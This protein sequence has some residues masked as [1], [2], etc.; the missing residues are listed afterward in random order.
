LC[1]GAALVHGCGGVGTGGTGAFASGPITGYG[2]IV[3]DGVFF[4]ES[5]ARIED[6][7]GI[8]R[9]RSELRLGSMVEIDSEEIRN[10]AARASRVRIASAAVGVVDAVAPGA[11]VVNGQSVHLNAGTVID[12][13]FVGGA[14]GIAPGRVVEVHGLVVGGS[15]ELIATR[16]QP[17]DGATVFK[18]RGFV[19]ALDTQ[20]RHFRIGTQ[21]FAY[22]DALG[23]GGALRD[24]AFV[25][26]VFGTVRDAQGRWPV[27]TLGGGAPDPGERAQVRTRGVVTSFTSNADFQVDGWT[28]DATDARIDGG[29]LAA[30]L[31]VEIEGKVHNG[32]LVAR[33]VVVDAQDGS[34]ELQVH[35]NIAA[36][37]T[38]AKTFDL[39][40]RRERISY[41]RNDIVFENGSA[42]DL[43]VGR[44]VHAFGRL[45]ADGTLLEATRISIDR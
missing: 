37:D 38:A 16:V 20:A 23:G 28:V 44:R 24:G 40:G 25:R 43:Q 21:D 41:A 5:A 4:D 42:A 27:G 11:L 19:A 45:S 9:D 10:D 3:V 14:A 32:V 34:D 39:N 6:D 2:S 29:A 31:R 33:K 17:A 12:D 7:D 1:L 26:V 36:I 8:G 35:G 15:G 18:V 30:G 13:R 22:P